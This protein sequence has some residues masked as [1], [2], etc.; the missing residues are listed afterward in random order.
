[1]SVR[2]RLRARSYRGD[3]VPSS[4]VESRLQAP[5]AVVLSEKLSGAVASVAAGHA[6]GL[7][8][9]RGCQGGCAG[10]S[11]NGLPAPSQSPEGASAQVVIESSCSQSMS[12]L[13]VWGVDDTPTNSSHGV[14]TPG[15]EINAEAAGNWGLSGQGHLG[16]RRWHPS[17]I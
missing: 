2:G 8:R 13:A 9:G 3:E 11:R 12:T 16:T 5:E 1:M 14:E 17:Q 4:S 7:L 10:R 6:L 15:H